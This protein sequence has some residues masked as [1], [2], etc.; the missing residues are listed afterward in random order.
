MIRV[1]CIGVGHWGPNLVRNFVTAPETEVRTVCDLREERL[2]LIEARIPSIHKTSTDPDATV[3]DPEADAIVIATPVATHYELTKKA[4][5]AGKHVLVEKPLC[6]SAA[7]GVEL[8]ELAE[9][10]GKHLCVGHIFLFNNGVRGV[11]NLIRSGE[12]G[13]LRYLFSTR[14]NLGPFRTDVNALWDLAAHDLSIFNYWLDS[15]PIAVTARGA[16][17]LNGEVEDVVVASYTY[18]NGVLAHVHASWLN[19]RKVRE[20][21]VV[22]EQ[23]MVVW[24]DMDLNEPVRVYH[25]SVDI[26]R[27]PVYS[28]SFGEF[29]MLIRNGDVVIPHIGGGE[30]LAAEC[31]HFIDCVLG[32][33]EPIIS[34]RE[35]V[36]VL[37]ALEAADRSIR[38]NS[39][40]VPVFDRLKP[41]VLEEAT[42]SAT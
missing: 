20:I 11:R 30:P 33:S 21:T 40:V 28:D 13:R 1:N 14:T 9:Q 19:P 37:L 22:G 8:V 31:R 23:K 26:E 29:R 16:A 12:L 35:G 36:K 5:E 42:I 6:E 24:N 3:V 25:K 17:Y 7:K 38:E 34:G 4:L 27:E 15:S 10:V 18:P 32:R 2:R 41:N 39:V